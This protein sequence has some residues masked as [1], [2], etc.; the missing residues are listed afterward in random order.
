MTHRSINGRL[1]V[2][3]CGLL[4]EKKKLLLIELHSPVTDTWVW[5]PP[6]GEVE[7]GESLEEAVK[8]EFMEET[9]LYVSVEQKFEIN[10]IIKPPIHAI[11]V[12]FL[13][14]RIGGNL[15][16]GEDPELDDD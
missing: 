2:R 14:K 4:V 6:G 9:G 3:S 11:E 12:Y 7:F 5:L 10:Q 8:R 13:V 15:A 16:L 1:R